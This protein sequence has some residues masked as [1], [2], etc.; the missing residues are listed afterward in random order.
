AYVAARAKKLREPIGPWHSSRLDLRGVSRSLDIVRHAVELGGFAG[1]KLYPPAGFLP[2]GNVSRFGERS[3][4]RLDAALRALYAYCIAEDVP[5]LTHA[6]RSNGFEDGYN[7]LASPTGWERVLADYPGLRICF[8]HFGHLEGVGNDFRHPSPTSWASRFLQLIETHE[9]VYAD[10]GNSRYVYDNEY[11][12]HFDTVLGVL[13]GRGTDPSD[14]QA[15]LRRR[16]MFG[17]DYWMNTFNPEHGEFVDTFSAGMGAL[18]GP[19]ATS[20]FMGGNA[21]RWLGI[22]DDADAPDTGNR[23]RQ[24][25]ITFYG[26]NELPDWLHD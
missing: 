16:L 6:A 9:H 24:R 21:L 3:G 18:V 8:G 17:S 25:L 12:E 1:V 11:R 19:D 5:I 23:N 26:P 14:A 7:D 13:L 2:I 22:T 15:K 4:G 10:V 20:S